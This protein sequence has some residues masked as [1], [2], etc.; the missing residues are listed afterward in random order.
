MWCFIL[1]SGRSCVGILA[2][3]VGFDVVVAVGVSVCVSMKVPLLC[4]SEFIGNR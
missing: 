3:I 1:C 2:V 4:E